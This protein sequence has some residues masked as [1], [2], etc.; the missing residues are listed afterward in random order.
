MIFTVLVRISHSFDQPAQGKKIESWLTENRE[1]AAKLPFVAH[2]GKET[3]S[4]LC[5]WCQ[6]TC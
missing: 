5:M 3:H 4:Q 2:M 6:G 1:T